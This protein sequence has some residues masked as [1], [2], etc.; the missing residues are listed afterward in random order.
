M[1]DLPSDRL[2]GMT[3]A[4]TGASGNLGTALLRRLTAPDSG[5]AEVRG[6]ARRRPPDIEPYSGVRW[7]LTDLGEP[8]CEEALADFVAGADA[9]VHLAWA[10]QPCR[11]PEQ[12]AEERPVGVR[13]AAVEDDVRAGDH[14]RTLRAGGHGG[15]GVGGQACPTRT[16]Q[17]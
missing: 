7:H 3:V 6:L 17:A 15:C 2:R 9:V 8:R 14:G 13:I 11:E 16:S 10:L 4:V 1:A 5:V 12:V